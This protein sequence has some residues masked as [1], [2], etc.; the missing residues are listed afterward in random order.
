MKIAVL[1]D[2]HGNSPALQAVINDIDAWHPDQV[3]VNG[4]IVNRGP[5]SHTVFDYL[6]E[7]H[8]RDDWRLLR[9]NHETYLLNLASWEAVKDTP[10]FEVNRFAY[11]AS[12]QLN[13]RISYLKQMPDRYDYFAPDGSE[14]RTAHASMHSN[15]EGLYVEDSDEL[16]AQR[17]TPAPAV[18]VTSHTHQ[19][20]VREVNG[21]LVVNVGSAGAPFDLDWRPSYGCF[22]WHVSSGW[23]A[24]I[25]RVVYD[26]RLIEEDYVRSGF[27]QEAGPLAQIMLV[28]LRQARGLMHLWAKQYEN[29]VLEGEISVEE[30]VKNILLAENI[31]P[32][33][34]PPGWEL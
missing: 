14:F 18:F 6:L 27:L 13:E 9:G 26:R 25:R 22:T 24:E 30:S 2:I 31:R 34:G 29:A 16:L 12:Q 4:D 23:R 8:Y 15:R 32:F 10:S 3:I 7:R 21:S 33:L 1:S 5:C 19:A 28:E 20:F 17:I 11:W